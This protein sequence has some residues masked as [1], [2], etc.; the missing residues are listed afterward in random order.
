MAL[1]FRQKQEVLEQIFREYRRDKFNLKRLEI[2]IS[3]RN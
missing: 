3:I 1:T 2:K